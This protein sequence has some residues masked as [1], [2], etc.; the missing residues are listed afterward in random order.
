MPGYYHPVPPGQNRVSLKLALMGSK[1]RAES[2]NPFGV[3]LSRT[4]HRSS[5]SGLLRPGFLAILSLSQERFLPAKNIL[6]F[7][8]FFLY[9]HNI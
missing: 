6:C 9:E 5:K 7:K 8:S 2:F 4:P 3:G 1:P